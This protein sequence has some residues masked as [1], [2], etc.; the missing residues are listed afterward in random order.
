MQKLIVIKEKCPQNHPCPSV[1][2]CPVH[3]LKQEKYNAP[4]V[5]NDVCINCAKCTTFCPKGVL[6][7][8]DE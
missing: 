3:A 6:K 8:V 1:K 2:I 7:L 5:D 4:I